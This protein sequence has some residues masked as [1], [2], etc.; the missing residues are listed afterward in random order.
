MTYSI[1]SG[2]RVVAALSFLLLSSCASVQAV[3]G[4]S[5]LSPRPK[6][7]YL[8]ELSDTRTTNG[9]VHANVRIEVQLPPGKSPVF[10]P[11]PCAKS[12]TSSLDV[13]PASSCN[14]I[15]WGFLRPEH[16]IGV[17]EVESEAQPT[18]VTL[19]A[20]DV[21]LPIQTVHGDTGSLALVFPLR[22]A[23]REVGEHFG[24]VTLPVVT[25]ISIR[26]ASV[27]RCIPPAKISDVGE[28]CVVPASDPLLSA[29]VLMVVTHEKS[30][31]WL[32]GAL[33]FFGILLGY[34][35]SLKVVQTKR[36]A[37][38]AVVVSVV[39][40]AAVAL[41]FLTVIAPDQRWKDPT[42]IVTTGMVAGLLVGLLPNSIQ[43][44]QQ[45]AQ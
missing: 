23:A 36:G 15:L 7:K 45:E 17:C 9:R 2:V 10:I 12:D 35:A 24:P 11:L 8:I 16:S 30:L 22:Q 18:V 14:Q 4:G 34:F 3:L 43:V 28:Y 38:I 33:G 6:C 42:T 41:L 1:R 27:T 25:E 19:L 5:P 39:G 20:D 40:L 13:D 44:L 37:W 31:Y 26:G 21:L 32:Y 29:D